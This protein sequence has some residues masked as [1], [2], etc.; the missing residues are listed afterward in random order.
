[1]EAKGHFRGL[2]FRLTV[3]TSVPNVSPGAGALAKTLA[4]V[5]DTGRR[6]SLEAP[7]EGALVEAQLG[8]R[9]A[10]AE[11]PGRDVVVRLGGGT[12]RLETPLVFGEA[13]GSR[14]DWRFEGSARGAEAPER[15]LGYLET[16][17]GK[18]RKTRLCTGRS[19][20]GLQPDPG[21]HPRSLTGRAVPD[22]GSQPIQVGS[23]SHRPR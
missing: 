18:P 19:H 20:G 10:L 2:R 11:E 5:L 9:R 6:R 14:R 15:G 22:L 17:E 3:C 12:Y 1:M 23:R 4:D 21:Q 7:G 13:D 16:G 8:V